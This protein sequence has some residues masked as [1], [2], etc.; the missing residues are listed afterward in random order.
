VPFKNLV[1]L[2]PMQPKRPMLAHA[3]F[4]PPRNDVALTGTDITTQT[5]IMT[6]TISSFTA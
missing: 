4:E 1:R 6:V 3:L 2:V 5:V